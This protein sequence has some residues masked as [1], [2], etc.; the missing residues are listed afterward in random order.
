ML[1]SGCLSSKLKNNLSSDSRSVANPVDSNHTGD[2]TPSNEGM[3]KLKV[4]TLKRVIEALK[5]CRESFIG[6][7]IFSGFALLMLVPAFFMLNVYD[8]G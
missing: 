5:I 1:R 6:V 4:L 8:K 2:S 7:G 3:L